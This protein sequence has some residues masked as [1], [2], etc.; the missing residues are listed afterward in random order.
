MTFAIWNQPF[1]NIPK[2][3]E[4]IDVEYSRT[5]SSN[6]Y[7]TEWNY[8]RSGS[9][10][11]YEFNASS[12]ID[13]FIADANNL[14]NW[15]QGGSPSF[16]ESEIN[17]DQGSGTFVV[18]DSQ[19]YYI[20]WYNEGGSSVDVDYT[21]NYTATNVPDFSG[22]YE[23]QE[24][25]TSHS[26]TFSPI[27][28]PGNW[29]FFIYFDPMISP[30]EST[31]ITFDVTYDTGV[32]YLEQWL[33]IRWILIIILV[34][35]VIIIIAAVVARRGQKKLK[36]KAPTTPEQKKVS[37]YKVTPPETVEKEIKCTR[38]DSPLKPD[39]KFC[40]KCGGKV[41]GRQVGVPS[42]T[43]PAKKKSCS[44]CGSKLTG[45]ESFC[46]WCGTKVEK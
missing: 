15:D 42:I 28:S 7:W 10:I 29:Y 46:K 41:E 26:G 40:P 34:V 22:T 32:T 11:Q 21:I 30:D 12:Q 8:L 25:V 19:D 43:T 39:A 27:P 33:D 2:T 23:T 1:E 36:L 20:V 17:I 16:W 37:P 45:T 6:E 9:L 24:G 3:T 13:F 38:C 14:Y 5:L 4:Y 31:T 18:S 35:V 44:L